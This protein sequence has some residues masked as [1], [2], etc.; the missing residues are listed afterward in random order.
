[1]SDVPNTIINTS[2]EHI[3]NFDEWY[4]KIPAGKL[5]ILQSNDY[6]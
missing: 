6:I 1:M 3:V 5:V 4:R 2:C